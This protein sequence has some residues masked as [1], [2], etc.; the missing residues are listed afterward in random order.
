VEFICHAV[1]DD[2]DIWITKTEYWDINKNS[3]HK[4]YDSDYRL[5]L[6]GVAIDEFLKNNFIGTGRFNQED[7]EKAAS[8]LIQEGL[9]ESCMVFRGQ[10]RYKVADQRLR[11]MI[12]IL[13]DFH[14]GEFNILLCK[15]EDF[16]KPTDKEVERIRWLLG[17]EESE[18]IF[19]SAEMKRDR[20]KELMKTSK[21]LQEYHN[22]Y[23]VERMVPLIMTAEYYKGYLRGRVVP[24]FKKSMFSMFDQYRLYHEL[25]GYNRERRNPAIRKRGGRQDILKFHKYRREC[26]IRSEQSLQ[27]DAEDLKME[28]A[29][30][31]EE[32]KFL[33]PAIRVICPLVFEPPDAELQTDI[34]GVD[35]V[36]E[37]A[38]RKFAK[39]RGATYATNAYDYKRKKRV[40]HKTVTY[41]NRIT[42]RQ[43][44]AKLVYMDLDK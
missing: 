29:D 4:K 34:V 20:N 10:T 27:W 42:G 14:Y 1:H 8:L 2:I 26:L 12:E 44:T 7:V 28:N 43:T 17:A 5:E 19:R 11:H 9:L 23:L 39:K 30:V 22:R 15:W 35:F 6:P 13:R 21:S 32:Y 37:Q 33:H 31:L 40:R 16:E 41:Y 38:T 24:H 36:K 25:E 18:R 3:K